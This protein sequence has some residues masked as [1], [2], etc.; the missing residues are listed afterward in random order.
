M[1]IQINLLVFLLRFSL[2]IY[3]KLKNSTLKYLH[4]KVCVCDKKFVSKVSLFN[5]QY[6]VQNS[7][8]ST[9]LH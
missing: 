2:S 6:N 8:V 7:V 9:F 5:I 1:Y 4:S 3:D